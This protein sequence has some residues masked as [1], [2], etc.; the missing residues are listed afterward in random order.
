M[1]LP[2]INPKIVSLN[3]LIVVLKTTENMS[4]IKRAMDEI[5]A[6]GWPVTNESLE[7]LNKERDRKKLRAIQKLTQLITEE[8]ATNE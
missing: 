4:N 8:Y 2:L 5:K 3:A 7:K 6:R 1:V